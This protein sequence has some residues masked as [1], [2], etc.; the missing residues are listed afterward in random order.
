MTCTRREFIQGLAVGGLLSL[1]DIRTVFSLPA[2]LPM[3]CFSCSLGI[4]FCGRPPR[5]AIH[6]S[7]W[8]PVGFIEVNKECEF[9][10][11]LIPL[12]G[13]SLQSPLREI[14]RQVPIVLKT[15]Q[16]QAQP[17]GLVGQDYMRFHARW[18]S[19]PEALQNWV[20]QVLLTVMLCPC[21]GL[22]AIFS[23][24][25]NLPLVSE[26]LRVYQETIN[27]VKEAEAK[28]KEG[29]K[30]ALKPISDGLA[31][32][33]P[34]RGGGSDFS[35]AQELLQK[36]NELRK[37][38]PVF[39]TE[40]FSPIWLSD[41]LTPDNHTAPAIANAIQTLISAGNPIVGA[42]ICPFLTRELT[43]RGL[44]K[45]ISARGV[46]VFDPE[47]LCVGYWGKGYPRI[48]VVR[49]DNPDIAML[50]ASARFHHLFSKTFTIIPVPLSMDPSKM[51]Y[52]ILS[53][54]Q[55]E[56]FPIGRYGVPTLDDIR[57]LT[58]TDSLIDRF[59]SIAGRIGWQSLIQSV[60]RGERK[61]FLIVW[62]RE[63]K[64][65]C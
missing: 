2:L 24:L 28:V 23:S 59:K 54:K 25:L 55:T 5:P 63:S 19:L 13:S 45:E 36:V 50:L 12:V 42:L 14:C 30:Q 48:G 3:S 11:S 8:F 56:C 47:F 35:S 16:V 4:C 17:S 32:F 22:D 51:R 40:L 44:L 21:I 53:P 9:M 38:T 26:G 15:G 31:R 41:L 65:C 34:S 33:I 39:F 1:L 27:K 18:Y 62:Y 61:M 57:D 7:Y 29:V 58:D 60:S 10:S 20:R 43:S 6:V 52:Q 49:H 37:W 64:C 46:S